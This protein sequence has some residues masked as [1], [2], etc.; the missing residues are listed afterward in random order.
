MVDEIVEERK[1]VVDQ[2]EL[3]L[4]TSNNDIASFV[5]DEMEESEAKPLR[6]AFKMLEDYRH[7]KELTKET[8]IPS[9]RMVKYEH[10]LNL[11]ESAEMKGVYDLYDKQKQNYKEMKKQEWLWLMRQGRIAADFL[12]L[13]TA[14]V[15][16]AGSEHSTYAYSSDDN[17]PSEY[18]W[19]MKLSMPSEKGSPMDIV[20][21]RPNGISLSGTLIFCGSK[22]PVKNGKASL[23]YGIFEKSFTKHEIIFVFEDG[24]KVPGFPEM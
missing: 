20:V 22:L 17:T 13:D 9:I 6:E 2:I 5:C 21:E 24:N 16:A 14:E 19:Q 18:K 15:I 8:G 7:E 23:P 3:L 12:A 1:K 4:N 10:C 11:L